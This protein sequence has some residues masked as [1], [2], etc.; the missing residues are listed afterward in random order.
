MEGD[1]RQLFILKSV[2]HSFS[3]S[4]GLNVNYNKSFMV[5]I[6]IN[7]EKFNHLVSTFGCAKGSQPFTYVRLTLG[8]TKPRIEDY[9]PLI[10]KCERRVVSTSTILSQLGS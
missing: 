10:T 4:T 2:L 5:P 7:D 8:I 1:A 6:N 9:L 3:E